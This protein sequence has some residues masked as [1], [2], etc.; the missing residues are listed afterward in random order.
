MA[1]IVEKADSVWSR[2]LYPPRVGV[3]GTR[4]RAEAGVALDCNLESEA[5][6]RLLKQRNTL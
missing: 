4:Q 6:E 5:L 1:G 3:D 2:G